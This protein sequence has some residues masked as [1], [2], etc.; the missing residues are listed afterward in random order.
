MK[1]RGVLLSFGARTP[2]AKR[3]P[4]RAA[5][6]S[7]G[8]DV[9][10]E[11]ASLAD[12][13]GLVLCGGTDVD[14]SLYGQTREAETQEPDTERDQREGI[15]VREAISRNLSLFAICRGLQFLNVEQGGTL[16][17]HIEGHR[18]ADNPDAH[19]VTILEGTRLSS[20][21]GAGSYRV[22]S[23]HHQCVKSVAPGLAVSATAPDD[24][25]ESLERPGDAF[26]LAVQ[27]HP[28]ER[29][30]EPDGKLFQAFRDAVLRTKLT[31]Y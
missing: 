4:Y 17:Q 8:L 20:I 5:L 14:P 28:E 10:E 1:T 31:T 3:D 30:T 12:L 13:H 27:W 15:L 9:H 6:R 11:S 21:L 7:V 25:V 22:N 2:A 23:R 18:C 29:A 26:V 16:L 19:S 24:V